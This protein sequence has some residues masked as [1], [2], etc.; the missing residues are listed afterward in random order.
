LNL[1][2]HNFELLYHNHEQEFKK[3]NK[4]D[5]ALAQILN[6]T[7]LSLELDTFWAEQ[8]GAD[9]KEIFSLYGDRIKLV[10]LKDGKNHIPTAVGCGEANCKKAFELAVNNNVEWVIVELGRQVENPFDE[11]IKSLKYIKDNFK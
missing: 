3:Y 11:A 4:G 2:N 1:R 9:V 5:I 6:K 10:H 8:A 7:T